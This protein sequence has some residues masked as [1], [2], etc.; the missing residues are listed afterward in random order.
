MPKKHLMDSAREKAEKIV[1]SLRQNKQNGIYRKGV[2]LSLENSFKV[3]LDLIEYFLFQLSSVKIKTSLR[4]IAREHHVSHMTV[5]RLYNKFL[6]LIKN[7]AVISVEEINNCAYKTLVNSVIAQKGTPKSFS[8]SSH[9]AFLQDLVKNDPHLRLREMREQLKDKRGIDFSLSAIWDAL[10]NRLGLSWKNVS[11]YHKNR[12][13]D[14]NMDW[15]IK[16][17][18]ALHSFHQQQRKII[19][20][21]RR[22][23]DVSKKKN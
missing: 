13:S 3:M 1:N 20:V 11:Y 5:R 4:K 15:R 16:I 2:P 7:C 6:C 14:E 17:T 19:F 21:V 10:H 9:L 22:K 8:F 12:F 18:A 23:K